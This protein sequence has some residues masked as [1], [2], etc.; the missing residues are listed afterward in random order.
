M[1]CRV[2]LTSKAGKVVGQFS[3]TSSQPGICVGE[4]GKVVTDYERHSSGEGGGG[5]ITGKIRY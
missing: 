2:E 3:A 5:G 4:M 1:Q